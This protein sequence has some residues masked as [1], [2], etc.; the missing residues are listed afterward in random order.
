MALSDVFASNILVR[1]LRGDPSRYDFPVAIVGVRMGNRLLVIGSREPALTA[2]LA[3]VTGLSGGAMAHAAD[4]AGE[5]RLQA[6]ADEAGVLI[7]LSHGPAAP[8]PVA[9]GSLD[10]VVVE[11][12]GGPPEADF[13]EIRR[14]LRPGGRVV[15]LSRAKPPGGPSAAAL[16]QTVGAVFKAARIL[17]DYGG[18]TF[19]EAL[20][21]GSAAAA[22]A[23]TGATDSTS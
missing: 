10:L 22:G 15:A 21:P 11:A 20:K 12:I 19:V 14:V 8:L 16:Q 7:D 17:A 18:W 1:W 4:A 13:A 23:G 9:E 3:K 2:A 5:A 6:A